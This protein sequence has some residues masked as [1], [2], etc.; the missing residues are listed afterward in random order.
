VRILPLLCGSQNVV[1]GLAH[2]AIV[3]PTHLKTVWLT[4]KSSGKEQLI[5]VVQNA[6]VLEAI[7][8]RTK[9]T[10]GT[11]W[12]AVL[13]KLEITTMSTLL[14]LQKQIFAREI[15]QSHSLLNQHHVLQLLVHMV[16]RTPQLMLLVEEMVFGGLVEALLFMNWV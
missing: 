8:T 1:N 2:P 13:M 10:S 12:F 11:I 15:T 5:L 3:Q 14:V 4:H 7:L 9:V 16:V 6:D